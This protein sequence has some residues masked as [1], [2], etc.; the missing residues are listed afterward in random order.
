[1][2][3][4][5]II[6]EIIESLD[7][8]S[9][10]LNI[11]ENG[12]PTDNDK[13]FKEMTLIVSKILSNEGYDK[14]FRLNIHNSIHEKILQEI[15]KDEIDWLTIEKI[16]NKYRYIIYTKG[17]SRTILTTLKPI[18]KIL[19]ENIRKIYDEMVDMFKN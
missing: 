1:M 13:H 19:P 16:M 10:N 11:I 2:K 7:I 9:R 3:N 15:L 4:D 5:E 14:N 12:L 18:K 17:F 8:Y 6:K